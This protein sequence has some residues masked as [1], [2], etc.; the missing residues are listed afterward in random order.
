MSDHIWETFD[1]VF[2]VV[3]K[4]GLRVE[5]LEERIAE[6]EKRL[7]DPR[8]SLYLREVTS[9]LSGDANVT[10]DSPSSLTE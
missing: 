5:E 1:A 4:Q 6:L 8:P 7:N 9:A 3:R 2:K 10:T